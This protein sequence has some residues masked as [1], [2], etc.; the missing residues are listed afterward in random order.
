MID[1]KLINSRRRLPYSYMRT[2]NFKIQA[3]LAWNL[4]RMEAEHVTNNSE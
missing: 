2:S 1:D 4:D 3:S